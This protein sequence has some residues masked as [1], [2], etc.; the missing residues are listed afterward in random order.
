VGGGTQDL[1]IWKPGQ[2]MENAVK[3]VLPA[4][5]QI[6]AR[7]I[8]RITAQGQ[9]LFLNGRVMGGGPVTQAL[10]RHLAQGL[11]AYAT[12]QA[13]YTFSDRL[14]LIKEWGVVLTDTPPPQTAAITLG[15]LDVEAWRSLLAQWEIPFPTHFAV[16]VQ[17]HGFYPQ[18][19]NRA[20]RFQHWQA[21]LN[22]GGRLADLAYRQ[23]PA[24]LT[25]MQ[26]VAETLPGVLLMD[27]C[28]AGVRGALL[29]PRA[30][31]R[32]GEGVMVVNLGNAHTFAVLAQGERLWGI[33]EHHTGLLT[34][35][36]L[37]SHLARF[38]AGELTHEE[39]FADHG[40][41]CAYGPEY[42]SVRSFPFTV[43]TGPQ[44]RLARGWPGIFAS[45][46][47]D[48]MLTG[49]FGLAAAFLEKE[50]CSHLLQD[51]L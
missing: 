49:C 7:R 5:T 23:P 10:R 35:S 28:A 20:F 25:R 41:G 13:A 30:R 18:G 1:L 44:R 38:Q 3:M 31:E 17:D 42:S 4:P 12:P 26:A 40:H 47:G 21:F 39:V 32:Q 15:D 19:S 50:S 16:A 45:P 9:P 51:S 27:T 22:Q 8:A 36:R 2:P 43:I 33:Y 29:D 14:D 46:F 48:M 6:L 37:F 11:A 24:Y 34:P